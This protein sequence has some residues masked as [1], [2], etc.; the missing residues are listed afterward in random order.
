MVL[1]LRV[2]LVVQM[3]QETQHLALVEHQKSQEDVTQ[4]QDGRR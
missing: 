4:H 2:T 1:A 3:L